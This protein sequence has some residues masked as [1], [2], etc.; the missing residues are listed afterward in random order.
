MRVELARLHSELQT[1]MVYVTHDQVEAMTLADRIVVF[2]DGHIEQV[3]TPLELYTKPCNRFVAGF[4]GSPNM[5]FIPVSLSVVH[6]RLSVVTLEDGAE[7][8]VAVDTSGQSV[9]A[10]LTLG[11]RPEHLVAN[12]EPSVESL[13]GVVQATEHLGNITYLYLSVPGAC[14]V[15]VRTDPEC[16]F[17]AGQTVWLQV[18]AARAHLF[19]QEGLALTRRN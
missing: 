6:E 10:Q 4:I 2:H 1:T 14:H 3:G 8:S 9:G 12:A 7:L 15:V 16:P 17:E 13:P 5:N 18:P 19:T 11:V